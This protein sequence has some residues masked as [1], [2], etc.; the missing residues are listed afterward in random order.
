MDKDDCEK[1][2]AHTLCNGVC[3]FDLCEHEDQ[4]TM[5]LVFDEEKKQ[6]V[7]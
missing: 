4:E 2:E 1:C 3:G 6:K 5:E 7:T